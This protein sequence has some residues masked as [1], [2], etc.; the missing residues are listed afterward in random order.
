MLPEFRHPRGY[1]PLHQGVLAGNFGA[2]SAAGSNMVQEFRPGQGFRYTPA[3]AE[4]YRATMRA[5][6]FGWIGFDR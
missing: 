4:E 5:R 1:S 2:M 3:F 6:S